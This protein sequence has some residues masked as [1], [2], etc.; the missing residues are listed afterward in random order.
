V[1][2]II[3]CTEDPATGKHPF[4][5]QGYTGEKRREEKKKKRLNQNGDGGN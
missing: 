2:I 4:F 1:L 5:F 3:S